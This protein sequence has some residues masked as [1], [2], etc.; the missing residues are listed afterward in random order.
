MVVFGAIVKKPPFGVDGIGDHTCIL[1]ETV[2]DN[3]RYCISFLMGGRFSLGGRSTSRCGRSCNYD[4]GFCFDM[5][6]IWK[7]SIAFGLVHI[8]VNLYP[9]TETQSISSN[10]CTR[11]ITPESAICASL[12]RPARKCR[13]KRSSAAMRWSGTISW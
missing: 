1:Y 4:L 13:Q 8:P 2:F 3:T 7:G 11:R 5:R 12:K 6:A 10:C 9:A